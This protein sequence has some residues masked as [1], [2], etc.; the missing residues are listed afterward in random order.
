MKQ[1]LICVVVSSLLAFC[2]A[3]KVR[4]SDC[5]DKFKSKISSSLSSFAILK[6]FFFSDD[7]EVSEVRVNSAIDENTGAALIKRSKNYTLEMDFTPEFDGED[8]TMLAYAL[9]P[10]KDAKFEGMDSNACNWMKCPVVNG[11]Q[12]TYSYSLAMKK[13]YLRGLFNVRWSMKKGDD[14]KCCFIVKIKIE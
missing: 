4:I 12:Q 3:V 9:L 1:F 13:I 5:D 7:C 8:I 2:G 10:G 11:T 14:Y 6:Q